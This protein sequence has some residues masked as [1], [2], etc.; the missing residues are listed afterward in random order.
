LKPRLSGMGITFTAGP[1]S[2]HSCTVHEISESSEF[3]QK[4]WRPATHCSQRLQKYIGP[5]AHLAGLK[6]G[7]VLADLDDLASDVAARMWAALLREFLADPQ[8]KMV[9]A[10]AFT[11]IRTGL[12]GL[13][14]R[15]VS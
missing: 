14:I 13:G 6:A 3:A 4:F 2:V 7:N 10:Q 12:C 5:T 11:P 9:Q 15:H 1:P 8:V